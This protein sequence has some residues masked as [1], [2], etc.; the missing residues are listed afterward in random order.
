MALLGQPGNKK[1]TPLRYLDPFSALIL[2]VMIP[3]DDQLWLQ[4]LANTSQRI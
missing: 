1:R 3:I 2:L 4:A